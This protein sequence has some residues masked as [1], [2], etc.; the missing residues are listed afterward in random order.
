MAGNVSSI[1][2]APLPDVDLPPEELEPKRRSD[3]AV[4]YDLMAIR[5]LK[6]G[7]REPIPDSFPVVI[8]PGKQALF[9]PGIA[10]AIPKG[11]QGEIRPRSGLS[12][13]GITLG[14]S[15]GT[16]DP[17]YRG[18]VGILLHN[19]SPGPFTVNQKDCIAQLVFTSVELPQLRA[20]G[21]ISELPETTRGIGGFGSTG[22]SGV[23]H[24]TAGADAAIH[25]ADCYLMSVAIETAAMSNCVRGCELEEDGR[26]KLD[27]YG[28]LVGQTRR[29]GAVF[30]R[31]TRILSSGYNHQVKGQQLCAEVGCLRDAAGIPSGHEL[32][33]CRAIHAEEDA[34]MTAG[35]NGIAL[36]GSTLYVNAQPCEMCAKSLAT[37]QLKAVVI[38]ANTYPE[39]G[40]SI[41]EN[42]EIQVRTISIDDV[43]RYQGKAVLD[44]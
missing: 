8:P 1:K 18:E 15:I 34:I 44:S 32:E 37:L 10:M 3:D 33:K 38:L 42:A 35:N 5:H 41:I 6:E 11:Y 17:D 2:Y 22:M 23:G 30:A 14:N 9:G 40:V 36:E 26:A 4:G 12:M 16:I 31:G 13:R 19:N 7:T 39:S 21:S 25:K 43:L 28:N 29:F 20:V 27:E 24:G